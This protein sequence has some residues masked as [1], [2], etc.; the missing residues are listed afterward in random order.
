MDNINNKFNRYGLNQGNVSR[1]GEGGGRKGGEENASSEAETASA[2]NT[3][4]LPADEIFGNLNALAAGQ[5][6]SLLTGR[7]AGSLEPL[8]SNKNAQADLDRIEKAIRDEL[9]GYSNEEYALLASEIFT[10]DQLGVPS[11]SLA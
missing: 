3:N 5:K 10:N 2:P 9:P 8:F 4:F 7:I 1:P 11:I 6:G